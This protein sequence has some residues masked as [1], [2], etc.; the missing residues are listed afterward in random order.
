[1]NK[2][3]EKLIKRIKEEICVICQDVLKD[4][5]VVVLLMQCGHLF[6]K[7]CFKTYNYKV[8]TRCPVC[9]HEIKKEDIEAF[10]FLSGLNEIIWIV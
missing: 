3:S 9:R 10:V 4:A 6:D 2:N 8:N 7:E 5:Y 1:M